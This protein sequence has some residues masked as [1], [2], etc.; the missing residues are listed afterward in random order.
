MLDA[1]ILDVLVQW[2]RRTPGVPTCNIAAPVVFTCETKRSANWEH[3]VPAPEWWTVREH[4]TRGTQNAGGTTPEGENEQER[5]ETSEESDETSVPSACGQSEEQ[6]PRVWLQTRIRLAAI[7]L[8]PPSLAT[9][10][11]QPLIFSPQAALWAVHGNGMENWILSVRPRTHA[12]PLPSHRSFLSHHPPITLHADA[13]RCNPEFPPKRRAAAPD[14]R[15]V[16]SQPRWTMSPIKATAVRVRDPGLAGR[17]RGKRWRGSGGILSVGFNAL[18]A[19]QKHPV[20]NAL[21]SGNQSGA[22]NTLNALNA[23]N[24]LKSEGGG[25]GRAAAGGRRRAGG[26]VIRVGDNASDAGQQTSHVQRVKPWS[27][28]RQQRAPAAL[29]H[30]I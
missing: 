3:L 18:N 5:K 23:F 24:A 17:Q 19:G 6:G 27:R 16:Y 28:D 1:R 29:P 15:P 25:G 10:L 8:S 21:N 4:D 2:R 11:I 20:F 14:S 9:D 22:F 26:G 7:S 12:H 30:P 13:P